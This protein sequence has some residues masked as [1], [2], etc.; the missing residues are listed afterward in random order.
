MG[1]ARSEFETVSQWQLCTIQFLNEKLFLFKNERRNCMNA[2]NFNENGVVYI[3][4]N[5]MR[6][7][8][9]Q[10]WAQHPKFSGVWTKNVFS[11]NESSGALSVVLVKIDPLHEIGDHI[12]E[13]KTES[14][15][16]LSGSG[17]AQIGNK[18]VI[19]ASGVFS[20]I[21]SDVA[22]SIHA[23][24]EGLVVVAIFTPPLN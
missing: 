22:H 23:N 8:A 9:G 6:K 13:G 11:G 17:T 7:M 14:H 18:K 19:Y 10:P 24:E 2:T 5:E 3:D 15:E 1:F 4:G 21:P 12:H 16:I 20:F